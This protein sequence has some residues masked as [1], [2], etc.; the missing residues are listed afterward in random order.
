VGRLEVVRQVRPGL[1]TELNDDGEIVRLVNALMLSIEDLGGVDR[2]FSNFMVLDHIHAARRGSL[3]KSAMV[4]TIDHEHEQTLLITALA[5]WTCRSLMV[6]IPMPW[7]TLFEYV[8]AL[9]VVYHCLSP[10]FHALSLRVNNGSRCSSWNGL[11]MAS[12]K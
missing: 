7:A 12:R 6:D 2:R 4:H 9:K 5:F 3:L 10:M 1:E 11:E 8:I